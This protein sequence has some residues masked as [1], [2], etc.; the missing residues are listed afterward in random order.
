[1]EPLFLNQKTRVGRKIIFHKKWLKK[2]IAFINDVLREDGSF[3]NL[4]DFKSDIWH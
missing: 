3:M 2:N 1:M 4:H